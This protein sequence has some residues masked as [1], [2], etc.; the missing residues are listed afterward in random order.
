[1]GYMTS[2][3]GRDMGRLPCAVVQQYGRALWEGYHLH[4]PVSYMRW[5]TGPVSHMGGFPF[6]LVHSC[7]PH[8]ANKYPILG[9]DKC[10]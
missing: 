6:A 9:Y 3:N 1:M 5:C 4:G 7:I 10:K 8:A 2:G